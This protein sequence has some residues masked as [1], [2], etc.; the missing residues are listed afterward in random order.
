MPSDAYCQRL[1]TARAKEVAEYLIKKGIQRDRVKYKGYGKSQPIASDKTA[2]G[3][4]KN[5]RVEIKILST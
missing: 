2:T 3:R 4:K 5:Q 1:S